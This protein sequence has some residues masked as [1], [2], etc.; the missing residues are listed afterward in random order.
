MNEY[1]IMN[2]GIQYCMHHNCN[3]QVWICG[4]CHTSLMTSGM[5]C[6]LHLKKSSLFFIKV[7]TQHHILR[8][9][10]VSAEW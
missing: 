7:D 8:G 2:T 5:N 1:E 3:L 10:K 9:H 4:S 6:N